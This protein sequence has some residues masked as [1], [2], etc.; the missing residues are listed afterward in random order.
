MHA[1]CRGAYPSFVRRQPG[2]VVGLASFVLACLAAGATTLAASAAGAPRK[3]RPGSSPLPV[4]VV[5]PGVEV[6]GTLP[7]QDF[8][9]LGRIPTVTIT[10]TH[11]IHGTGVIA[12]TSGEVDHGEKAAGSHVVGRFRHNKRARP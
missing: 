1:N 12:V 10:E 6:G 7:V 4:T 8:G 2:I 9:R 5:V 3:E 11:V